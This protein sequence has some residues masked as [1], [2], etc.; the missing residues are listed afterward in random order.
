MAAPALPTLPLG[1]ALGQGAPLDPAR[2]PSWRGDSGPAR[3]SAKPAR[4]LA[5]Q[6][7]LGLGLWYS[8][9]ETE[10]EARSI[11]K[12]LSLFLAERRRRPSGTGGLHLI[13]TLVRARDV[14]QLIRYVDDQFAVCK[15]C[16]LY[17]CK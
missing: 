17:I 11:P 5:R 13:Y 12:H 8:G 4:S 7:W 15:N 16:F 10:N 9:R 2:R 1:E 6:P 3:R 14:V